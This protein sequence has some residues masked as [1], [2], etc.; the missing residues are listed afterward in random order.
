MKNSIKLI[1]LLALVGFAACQKS[2][3]GKPKVLLFTKTAGFHHNSI[4]PGIA[5]IQKLGQENGFDVDTTVDA[6]KFN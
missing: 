2:R 5:A 6:A 1:L 3:P 4:T